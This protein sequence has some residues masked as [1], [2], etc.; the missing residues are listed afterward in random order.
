MPTQPTLEETLEAL[1]FASPEPLTPAEIGQVVPEASAP[2]VE[3]ALGVL[4]KRYASPGGGLRILATAGGYRMTTRPEF[5]PALARLFQARNRSRLS[6]A[7]LETLAIVAYRQPITGPEIQEI[8]GVNSQAVLRNLLERK[9]VRILGR[10]PVVGKPLLYASTR[11]FLIHFGL[12]TLADLPQ[13]EELQ[14]VLPSGAAPPA[15]GAEETEAAPL[16]EATV[17]EAGMAEAADADA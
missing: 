2:E 4:V 9:L 1:L 8:R 5:A 15:E 16:A 14:E 12:N 17:E 10:K 11:E 13:V 3:R 6:Q 7:A